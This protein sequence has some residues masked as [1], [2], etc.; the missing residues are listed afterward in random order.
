MCVQ[1]SAM[2]TKN[3]VRNWEAGNGHLAAAE[4]GSLQSS[5]ELEP[6]SPDV[7]SSE[8]GANRCCS[9]AFLPLD[10]PPVEWAA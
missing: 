1:S 7:R 4:E 9:S 5:L 2:P 3:N 8:R 6:Y 10:I